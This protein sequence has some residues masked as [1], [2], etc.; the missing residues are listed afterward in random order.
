MPPGGGTNVGGIEPLPGSAEQLFWLVWAPHLILFPAI[1]ML[2]TGGIGFLRL[3]WQ[4]QWEVDRAS[5]K[6]AGGPVA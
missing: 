4:R 3:M 6:Q 5:A 1:Y 2:S